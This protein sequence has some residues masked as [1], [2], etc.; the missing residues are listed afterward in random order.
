VRKALLGGALGALLFTCALHVPEALAQAVAPAASAADVLAALVGKAV[1]AERFTSSATAG[2]SFTCNATLASCLKMPGADF[3]IGSDGTSILLGP[4]ASTTCQVKVG[5]SLLF[6]C[7]GEALVNGPLDQYNAGY[8]KNAIGGA[9][10]VDDAEGFNI[11]A[12]SLGTC[13]AGREGDEARDALAGGTTGALTRRCLCTSD[14]GTPAYK[15]QNM[16]SGNLGTATTCP[17]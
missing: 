10:K 12:K 5:A 4:T 14:G 9:V 11:A 16:V 3:V 1:V 15:W 6:K 17:P 13:A 8:F 2:A 7:N